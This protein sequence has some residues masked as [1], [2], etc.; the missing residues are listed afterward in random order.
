M[1]DSGPY[2]VKLAYE[3]WR[4]TREPWFLSEGTLA[5]LGR[6][7]AA[8]PH[9]PGGVLAWIDPAHDWERCPFGFTDTVRKRGECLF[10]SLLTYEAR[11]NYAA[12]L[13]AS[14]WFVW[15]LSL[16]DRRKALGV[17]SAL[18]EEGLPGAKSERVGFRRQDG[19]QGLSVDFGPAA[20]GHAQNGLGLRTCLGEA[21]PNGHVVASRRFW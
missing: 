4:R 11:K 9:A 5:L 19:L 21:R 10:S 3:S 8:V 15:T 6:V 16:T 13:E 2:T 14:G 1:L 18:R 17:F 7:L 20:A 12:L